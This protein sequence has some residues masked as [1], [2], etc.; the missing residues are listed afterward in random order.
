MLVKDPIRGTESRQINSNRISD[1]QIPTLPADVVN[2]DKTI[3][4]HSKTK[5][6]NNDNKNDKKWVLFSGR[7]KVQLMQK[8]VVQDQEKGSAGNS[9]G[10]VTLNYMISNH[11][12]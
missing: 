1:G 3:L 4:R 2:F 8:R 9:I 11:L 7:F 12:L 6:N 5:K 10:L